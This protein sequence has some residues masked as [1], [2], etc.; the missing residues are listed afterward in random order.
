MLRARIFFFFYTIL[1][2]FFRLMCFSS[3]TPFG[4]CIE[5]PVNLNTK[6]IPSFEFRQAKPNWEI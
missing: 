5:I 6:D 3:K 2:R 4:K 1:A